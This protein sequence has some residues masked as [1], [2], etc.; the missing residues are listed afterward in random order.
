MTCGFQA[1]LYFVNFTIYDSIEVVSSLRTL[2]KLQ[3]T[4]ELDIL[5]TKVP[6]IFFVFVILGTDSE[7]HAGHW[8]LYCRSSNNNS[9]WENGIKIITVWLMH[10]W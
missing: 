2:L 9:R 5:Q 3:H 4:V 6:G 1:L 8:I 10:V 7:Y